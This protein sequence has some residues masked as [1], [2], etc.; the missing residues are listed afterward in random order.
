MARW[1]ADDAS[2]PTCRSRVPRNPEPAQ[3][4]LQR[5]GRRETGHGGGEQGSCATRAAQ[6]AWLGRTA[7]AAC[8]RP[9]AANHS[10]ALHTPLQAQQL[11]GETGAQSSIVPALDAA[12]GIQHDRCSWLAAYLGDQRA[13]MPRAHRA[14]I[15]SLEAGPSLREA[16]EA[17]PS[18][19]K[20]RGRRGRQWVCKR[21]LCLLS[22]L[23]AA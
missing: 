1:V 17:G 21:R 12:L 4:A 20:V 11:Y 3:C 23:A 18:S 22:Q 8:R 9:L 2:D 5:G 6:L 7:N 14:F 13:H 16:A 10:A 15:A 19:L